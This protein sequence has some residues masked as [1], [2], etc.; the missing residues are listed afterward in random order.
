MP[1][2]A[3]PATNVRVTGHVNSAD[4]FRFVDATYAVSKSKLRTILGA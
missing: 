1:A 2:A 3:L 4:Y